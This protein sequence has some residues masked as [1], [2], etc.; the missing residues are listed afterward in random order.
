MRYR[1]LLLRSTVDIL[2]S[3]QDS[4]SQ[5]LESSKRGLYGIHKGQLAHVADAFSLMNT[6]WPLVSK[7][8]ITKCWIMSTCLACEHE[9]ILRQHILREP[10]NLIDLSV[11]TDG[12]QAQMH[13]NDIHID[14][15]V[16]ESESALLHDAC[17]SDSLLQIP[18]T[19]LTQ[20]LPEK[21]GSKTHGMLN[22]LPKSPVLDEDAPLQ[23]RT[24]ANESQDMFDS[25]NYVEETSIDDETPN[26]LLDSD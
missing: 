20:F 24:P 7:L 8:C 4:S 5:F 22:S 26:D 19:P 11:F 23:Y 3:R 10:E 12:Y 17:L 14:Q 21:V 6:A 16:D 25:P 13:I 1:S 18:N 15:A 2:L 9:H